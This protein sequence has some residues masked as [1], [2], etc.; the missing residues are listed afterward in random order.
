MDSIEINKFVAAVLIA[1]IVFFLSGTVGL[2][3]NHRLNSNKVRKATWEFV[4]S[5][6]ALRSCA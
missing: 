1:G 6:S 4:Q 3:V 2:G 5:P